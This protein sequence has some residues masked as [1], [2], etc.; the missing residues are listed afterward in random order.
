MQQIKSRRRQLYR[1]KKLTLARLK[2]ASAH[3]QGEQDRARRVRCVG[4]EERDQHELK[5]AQ[6]P[7]ALPKT[8]SRGKSS[9]SNRTRA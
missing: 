2:Y 8:W 9:Q 4:G 6:R 3:Q 7:L 1:P 5:P